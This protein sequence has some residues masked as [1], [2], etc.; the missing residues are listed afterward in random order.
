MS[1]LTQLLQTQYELVVVKR[2]F[3]S[4]YRNVCTITK[5]IAHTKTAIP[6]YRNKKIYQ[7][8][9]LDEIV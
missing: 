4:T 9:S 8:N 7:L 6:E 1:H 2:H 3:I 5:V